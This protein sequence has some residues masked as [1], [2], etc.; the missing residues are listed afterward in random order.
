MNS[1]SNAL[2]YALAA[3]LIGA[4]LVYAAVKFGLVALILPADARTKPIT[5]A[6][7]G[8]DFTG[9]VEKFDALMEQKNVSSVEKA[10]AIWS[11]A[12]ARFEAT[13]DMQTYLQDI[14]LMKESIVDE[15]VPLY[16]RVSLINDVASSYCASGRTPEVFAAIYSGEPFAQHLVPGDPNLSSRK[17]H[18]WSWSL[19]PTAKAAVRIA[20]WYAEEL[21]YNKSLTAAERVAYTQKAKDLVFD[22]EGLAKLESERLK[23]KFDTSKRNVGY[24][25]WRAMTIGS[26]A[27][28]GD[29]ESKGQYR[30]E[31]DSFLAMLAN[32]DNADAR[33]DYKPYAELF[34]AWF[35]LNVDKD[36]AAARAHIETAVSSVR[37]SNVATNEFAIFL[38]NESSKPAWDF[39]SMVSE[40]M[41]AFSPAY[42]ALIKEMLGA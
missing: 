13:G 1:S 6:S 38:A 27:A 12:S 24:Q 39:A 22:G 25:F 36:E 37:N 40:E 29:Q 5:E 20:R 42:D 30:S 33:D 23:D 34:F 21:V 17:M 2:T 4:A 41:R 8:G 32:Y 15:T 31:F 26:L 14:E 18:E 19:R 10:R 7:R 9:A 3:L 28:A 16:I 11:V 35:L